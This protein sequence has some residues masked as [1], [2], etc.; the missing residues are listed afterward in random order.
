MSALSCVENGIDLTVDDNVSNQLPQRKQQVIAEP[1]L[2]PCRIC[3]ESASG[4]HYGANTC[5]A[6]KVSAQCIYIYL[7]VYNAT[8]YLRFLWKSTL[9]KTD[10]FYLLIFVYC[11]KAVRT[12]IYYNE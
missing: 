3:S 9:Q 10:I 2:P 8:A 11:L 12:Q 4:F 5:E 1:M 7:S 6:C